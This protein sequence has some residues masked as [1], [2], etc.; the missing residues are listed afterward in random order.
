[1]ERAVASVWE[2]LL[3]SVRTVQRG[4]CSSEN[5]ASTH[6][7]YFYLVLLFTVVIPLP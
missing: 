2:K 4:R 6:L 7:N 3:V 1:M 5:S